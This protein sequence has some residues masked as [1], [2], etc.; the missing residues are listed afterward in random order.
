MFKCIKYDHQA[1]QEALLIYIS[2]II[3]L[4]YI[5]CFKITAL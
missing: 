5:I 4:H 2:I 1:F 3:V